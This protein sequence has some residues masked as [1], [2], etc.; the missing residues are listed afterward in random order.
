MSKGGQTV[1]VCDD[2]HV[3]PRVYHHRYKLQSKPDDWTASV[4]VE[5]RRLIEV[6]ECMAINS[7]DSIAIPKFQIY[8]QKPRITMDN[9]F[10]G[11]KVHDWIGSKGFGATITYHHDRL[12]S[13]IPS[14]KLN[15]QKT[16]SSKR[17]KFAHFYNP[18]VAVK[19]FAAKDDNSSAY[20]WAYASF[21]STSSCNI[22]TV[23]ALNECMLTVHKHERGYSDNK[24]TWGI[25]MDS[26][27]E[28][29]L[30][31]SFQIDSIDHLNKN[32]R[33]KYRCWKY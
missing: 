22:G 8:D 1:L 25:E 23:N 18:V 30:S 7:D 14:K 13:N 24:R 33:L 10:S 16:D 12:P 32:C 28:L 26:C 2:H 29:Y 3:R 27:R 11:D 15:K 4:M 9:Y 31:T 21:Q 20:C 19:R 5:T 6:L 17:T